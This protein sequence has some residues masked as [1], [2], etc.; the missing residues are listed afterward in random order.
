MPCPC[1]SRKSFNV[2]C[3]PI[4]QGLVVAHTP[5]TLMR[6]RYTAFCLKDMAY[7]L[8]SLHPTR[9]ADFDIESNS[10]WAEQAQ[11]KELKVLRSWEKGAEGF[12]EF[13]AHFQLGGQS[14][15]H[16]EASRFR[17]ENGVWY[18]VDGVTS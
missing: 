17:R 18:F 10:K 13:E 2:C 4:V 7:L 3:Q 11:F 1:S 6:S 15:V 16:K 12:V 5:E 14:H 8:K 9:R